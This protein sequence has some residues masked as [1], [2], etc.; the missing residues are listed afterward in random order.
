MLEHSQNITQS[1]Y[2]V[3]KGADVLSDIAKQLESEVEK[4]KL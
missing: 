1:S 3:A 4:F 2:N